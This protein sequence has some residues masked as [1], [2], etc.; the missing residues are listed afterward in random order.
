LQALGAL[1]FARAFCRRGG[2]S[3]A[4]V[5]SRAGGHCAPGSRASRV[6]RVRH[7]LWLVIFDTFG[8]SLMDH[9][10]LFEVHH[11]TVLHALRA[12]RL[13][14]EEQIGGAA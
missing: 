14:L 8:L 4:E 13:E 6:V 12:Q 7:H 5:V 11:V 9:A 2:A 10:R 1:K 3:L